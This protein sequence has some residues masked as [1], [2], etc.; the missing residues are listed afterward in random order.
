MKKIIYLFTE[1]VQNGV[2]TGEYKPYTIK[3]FNKMLKSEKRQVKPTN[4]NKKQG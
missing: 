1:S 2:Y 3:Q 4:N